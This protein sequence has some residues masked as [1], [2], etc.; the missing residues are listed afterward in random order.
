L[1]IE[2]CQIAVYTLSFFS[3][4]SWQSTG[5]GRIHLICE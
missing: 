5:H 3:F 1:K 4:C 2:L